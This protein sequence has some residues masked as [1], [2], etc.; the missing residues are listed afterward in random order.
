MSDHPEFNPDVLDA[1]NRVQEAQ[2]NEVVQREMQ[3]LDFNVGVEN[4]H[5]RVNLN[6]QPK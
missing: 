3:R 4:R 1:F 2:K 5:L 6:K